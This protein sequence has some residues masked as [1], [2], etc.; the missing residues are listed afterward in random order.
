MR[1]LKLALRRLARTPLFKDIEVVGLVTNSK[2][3]DL[4]AAPPRMFYLL[5]NQQKR[6]DDPAI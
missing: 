3:T 5:Y 4:R 1:N 6:Q 2:Y